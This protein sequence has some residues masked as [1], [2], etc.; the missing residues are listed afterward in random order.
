MSQPTENRVIE[1][2]AEVIRRDKSKITLASRFIED[3]EANSLDVVE[4]VCLAEGEFG[5]QLPTARIA[6]IRT[7]GDVVHVLRKTN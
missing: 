1:L 7:V 5:V 6:G 4:L 3:L 2:V